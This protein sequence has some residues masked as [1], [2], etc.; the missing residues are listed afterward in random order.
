MKRALGRIISVPF[1]IIFGIICL[2]F[3]ALVGLTSAMEKVSEPDG[4]PPKWK[5]GQKLLPF[6][7]KWAVWLAIAAILISWI[8]GYGNRFK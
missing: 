5:K 4:S 2:P 6:V 8:L 3:L 1:W 7:G